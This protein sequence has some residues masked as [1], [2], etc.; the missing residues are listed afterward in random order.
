MF[1]KNDRSKRLQ[2]E[3]KAISRKALRKG[4]EISG[5]EAARLTRVKGSIVKYGIEDSEDERDDHQ[6]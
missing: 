1:G 2:R 5:R 3:A 6:R 4:C